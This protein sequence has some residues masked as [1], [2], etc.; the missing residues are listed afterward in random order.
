L[1]IYDGDDSVV[2]TLQAKVDRGQSYYSATNRM[3]VAYTTDGSVSSLG[4]Q[5]SY[6][7]A[8]T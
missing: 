1:Q 8:S 4:F 5:F 7:F 2:R 3:R 6:R